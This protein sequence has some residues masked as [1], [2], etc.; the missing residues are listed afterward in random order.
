MKKQII[1][2]CT[3]GMFQDNEHLLTS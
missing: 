1:I 2:S 3:S